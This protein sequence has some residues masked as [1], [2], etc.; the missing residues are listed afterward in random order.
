MR[1]VIDYR[2]AVEVLARHQI[3]AF[4]ASL[5]LCSLFWRDDK[6]QT[7]DDIIEQRRL[8]HGIERRKK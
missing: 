2:D 1:N 7:L 3:S 6:E 8:K 5:I 4:E